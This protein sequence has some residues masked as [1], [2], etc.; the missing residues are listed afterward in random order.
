MI[1][2]DCEIENPID[3]GWEPK[4]DGIQYASGWRDFEAMGIA[5][6]GC[7]DFEADRYRVFLKDNFDEF[8]RLIARAERVIGF[9][10]VSFDN[11]LCA[12][13]GIHV[14]NS[15]D[16]K[17]EM[18]NAAGENPETYHK[19]FSLDTVAR[20]NGIGGKNGSG[21]DAPINWQKG[22]IG[23][24]VD[25]CLEDVRLTKCLVERVIRTGHLVDPR[26]LSN[27]LRIARP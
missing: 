23:N 2:Y 7:Y 18:V 10:S 1:V 11:P 5:C 21:A 24:V 16:L 17:R 14:F 20:A 3:T 9:N 12:A 4:K 15:Y 26:N 19:G 6:I 22:R 8:R 27:R 13:H 25:Y